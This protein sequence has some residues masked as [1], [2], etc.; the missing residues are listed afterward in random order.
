M[1]EAGVWHQLHGLHIAT[2]LKIKK[3][4]ILWFTELSIVIATNHKLKDTR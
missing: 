4:K 1:V 3:I 2:L